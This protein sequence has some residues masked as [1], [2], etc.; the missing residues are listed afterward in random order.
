MSA[1]WATILGLGLGTFA[2]RFSFLGA[3]GGRPLPGWALRLLRYVP[4]AV[5]PA[6][7]APLVVYPAATGGETDPA[8]LAA[9]GVALVV[10]ATTR[11]ALWS[12][13]AGMTALYLALW[14]GS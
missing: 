12:I 4:V 6:L 10:G 3:V 1:E 13:G 8:R 14:V 9:A 2:I 11:N 7:A 5:M